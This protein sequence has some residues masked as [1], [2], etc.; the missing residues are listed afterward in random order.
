MD[1]SLAQKIAADTTWVL[2]ALFAVMAAWETIAPQ[3]PLQLSMARRWVQHF[4]LYVLTIQVLRLIFGI[5][6]VA[7]AISVRNS[8]YGLLNRPAIPY[9]A[10]FAAAVLAMDLLRYLMHR[11]FHSA[12]WLWRLH[13][14]HHSDRDYDFTVEFRFHPIES[15][16]TAGTNL[17]VI[18]L[19]APPALS[20]AAY[21]AVA[22]ILGMMAHGN[23]RL[24]ETAARLLS[25]VVITP[26][27]HQVHHSMDE[28]DLGRNLGVVFIWWD[29]LFGTYQAAPVHGVEKLQFGV[30]GVDADECIRTAHLI[31]APF[32]RN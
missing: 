31:A 22:L 10:R 5:G 9:A 15:I 20:V 27:L 19:L 3:R 12:G 8:P 29:R 14:L 28:G 17:L 21:E 2:V 24:P 1:P 26:E 16:L 13:L 11:A 6:S 25:Y 4:L 23:V 18:A 7:L 30:A 32:R